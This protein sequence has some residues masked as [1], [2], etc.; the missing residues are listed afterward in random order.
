MT[1]YDPR[2]V[3][4]LA[5]RSVPNGEVCLRDRDTADVDVALLNEMAAVETLEA[6]EVRVQLERGR[7]RGH[8]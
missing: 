2:N 1:A 4:Y 3:L 7:V 8:G 6:D 5:V